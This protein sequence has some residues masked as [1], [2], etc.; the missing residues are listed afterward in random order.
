MQNLWLRGT[1]WTF[2][3]RI[4]TD[5]VDVFGR[6]P[7]R[8]KLGLAG[9]IVARRRARFL[10]GQSEV[11]FEMARVK[12]RAKSLLTENEREDL[13]TELAR[14]SH[15]LQVAEAN[16]E[17][18]LQAAEVNYARALRDG[19]NAETALRNA[20]I[21]RDEKLAVYEQSLRS[22]EAALRSVH[23]SLIEQSNASQGS[24][25]ANLIARISRLE[26]LLIAAPG[27]THAPAQQANPPQGSSDGAVNEHTLL[28]VA[29][30]PV[31][32]MRR[33]AL[34]DGDGRPNR[35]ADRLDAALRFFTEIVGD[36]P[37]KAYMPIDLQEF[38]NVLG[39][40]PQNMHK[41]RRFEG[42]TLREAA[43]YNDG[44]P[45]PL[46]R[47]SQTTVTGYVTEVRSIWRIATAAVAGVRDI[48]AARVTVPRSA[49]RP[50]VREGLRPSA[51]NPWLASAVERPEPHFYWPPLVGLLSGMRLGE[52][53][54]LQGDDFEK[55]GKHWVIDLRKDIVVNGVTKRRPLKTPTSK[56][57]VAVH[58]FLVEIGFV[59]W[60]RKRSGLC[61]RR[62]SQ[63]QGSRRRSFETHD[64]L[65]EGSRHSRASDRCL[66][67]SSAHDKGL[68]TASRRRPRR[69]SAM[70]PCT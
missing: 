18:K 44:L 43:D 7:I 36:K 32:A 48:G 28:S 26:Q 60:A 3:I 40:I 9:R 62:F 25:D 47:L 34:Q 70:R 31:L 16:Y 54:Y 61:L 69:E 8:V 23:Q 38:A 30:A 63:G 42:M 22:H 1:S 35:Y 51:L 17:R 53:V 20:E 46:P 50:K 57:L 19:E 56:R 15:A 66:P 65:D 27:P 37:L 41:K 21:D 5:L 11:A 24:P 29:A 49:E 45:Q 12:K 10:A 52:L 4:P 55:K 14:S 6:T 39:R 13:I 68:A 33:E 2:Q 59:T 67:R 64:L 58:D